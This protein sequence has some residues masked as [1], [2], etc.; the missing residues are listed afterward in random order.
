M[1]PVREY[2]KEMKA[3]GQLMRGV[4]PDEVRGIRTGDFFGRKGTA[5]QLEPEDVDDKRVETE[6][7]D[8]SSETEYEDAER[9]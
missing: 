9:R 6:S 2:I 5:R 3:K 7:E 8:E 1:C 4:N